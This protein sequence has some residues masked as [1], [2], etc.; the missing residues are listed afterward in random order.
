MGRRQAGA[1]TSRP[2]L[3][4]ASAPSGADARSKFQGPHHEGARSISINLPFPPPFSASPAR[5]PAPPC[6]RYGAGF[7]PGTGAPHEVG[8]G[9]G[10]GFSVN[11]AFRSAGYS[12]A[13][14][15]SAFDQVVMP[16]ARQ[17]APELVLV[18]FGR[19]MSLSAMPRATAGHAGCGVAAQGFVGIGCAATHSPTP[20]PAG[21]P[22]VMF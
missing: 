15:A 7:Y 3:R 18:S 13:E 19:L 20:P 4:T 1:L 2:P 6:L 5:L 8:F 17:F 22:A 9:K 10:A 11:V 14:Y 21:S 12:D 16:V